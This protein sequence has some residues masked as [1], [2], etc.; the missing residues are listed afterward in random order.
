L[1]RQLEGNE[2]KTF[3]KRGD[4]VVADGQRIDIIGKRLFRAP[5]KDT[6]MVTFAQAKQLAYSV[7]YDYEYREWRAAHENVSSNVVI[8]PQTGP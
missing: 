4:A 3:W 8:R 2:V 7:L 5:M 1:N 6:D